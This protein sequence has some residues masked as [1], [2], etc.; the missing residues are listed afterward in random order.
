M[1]ANDKIVWSCQ[2]FL[3][4]T[5]WPSVKVVILDRSWEKDLWAG[6]LGNC[7]LCRTVPL[8]LCLVIISL[9]GCL[10]VFFLCLRFPSKQCA[11]LCEDLWVSVSVSRLCGELW[12]AL[13]SFSF[14]GSSSLASFLAL[15]SWVISA[16]QFQHHLWGDAL[17]GRCAADVSGSVVS[18][19]F[20][21]RFRSSSSLS[22]A[23]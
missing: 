4:S 9:F 12:R 17:L 8:G 13:G 11:L 21:W 1:N 19:P 2:L 15:C 23:A 6:S 3:L 16:S 5:Q 7:H 14:F 22:S 10:V 18:H 20:E